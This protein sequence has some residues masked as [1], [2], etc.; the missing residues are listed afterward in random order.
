MVVFPVKSAL[1]FWELNLHHII[2]SIIFIIYFISVVIFSSMFHILQISF[3]SL[4]RVLVPLI[5]SIASAINSEFYVLI[6]LIMASLITLF[7]GKFMTNLLCNFL[8]FYVM[9]MVISLSFPSFWITLGQLIIC[10]CFLAFTIPLNNL[11]M[12]VLT[13]YY[14]CCCI[15]I[16]VVVCGPL[17]IIY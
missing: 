13:C 2:S 7:F 17:L 11:C 8:I 14:L 4:D 12:S 5:S 16:C 1:W 3:F 15:L 9:F 10:A 6:S